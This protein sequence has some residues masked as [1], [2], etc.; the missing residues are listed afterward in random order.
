MKEKKKSIYLFIMILLFNYINRNLNS[1]NT[2][3]IS[4]FD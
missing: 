3:F 1:Y 4:F 2:P